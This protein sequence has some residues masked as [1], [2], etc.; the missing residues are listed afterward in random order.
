MMDDT[1]TIITAE[2]EELQ[3]GILTE[4]QKDVEFLKQWD[5]A[6][7]Y[8]ACPVGIT[9]LREFA[10]AY[11]SLYFGI[12]SKNISGYQWRPDLATNPKWIAYRQHWGTCDD[13]MEV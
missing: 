1:R 3:R 8:P 7:N 4:R 10:E 5:D 6:A 11:P 12:V 2:Q 13:C 9:L